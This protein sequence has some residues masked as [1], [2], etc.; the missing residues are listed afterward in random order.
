MRTVEDQQEIERTLGIASAKVAIFRHCNQIATI[1]ESIVLIFTRCEVNS[2]N[3]MYSGSKFV[4]QKGMT[5]VIDRPWFVIDLI[6]ES[7]WRE[8]C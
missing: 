2:L 7:D 6:R 3:I 1:Y 5:T 8:C 4:V